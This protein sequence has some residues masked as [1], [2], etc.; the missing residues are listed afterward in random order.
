M[1]NMCVIKIEIINE[2][3][4]IVVDVF[5]TFPGLSASPHVS[6]EELANLQMVVQQMKAI[7]QANKQANKQTNNQE[8]ENLCNICCSAQIDTFF[9]PVN[10]DLI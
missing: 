3:Y 10:A 7:K 5:S 6:K 4:N 2:D 9:L 1:S 8:E